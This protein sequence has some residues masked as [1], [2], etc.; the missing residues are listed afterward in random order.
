MENTEE[1]LT[2]SKEAGSVKISNDVI[3][4]IAA[5]AIKDMDEVRKNTSKVRGK[6]KSIEVTSSGRDVVI[7][8]D[9]S[10]PYGTKIPKVAS[11][12]QEKIKTSVETMTGLNVTSVN[13]IISGMNISQDEH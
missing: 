4:I 11:E 5:L 9:L 8:V 7:N 6:D 13:V 10:V 2:A 12:V 3:S 1:N